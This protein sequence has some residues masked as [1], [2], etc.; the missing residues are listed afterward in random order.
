VV[1]ERDGGAVLREVMR[2]YPT[3]VAVVAARTPEGDVLGMTATSFTSVSLRPPLVLVCV[4][5]ASSSHDRLVAGDSFC[6]NVLSVDQAELAVRFSIEPSA[7]RFA[8]VAWRASP[9]GNPILERSVAWLECE[10]AAVHPG[11]D[12]SILVARVLETG[13]TGGESLVLYRGTYR[14]FGP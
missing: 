4:D 11:G 14:S 3:G 1:S 5:V 7:S 8:G 6:V 10:V 12:H 13:V 2:H 9:R